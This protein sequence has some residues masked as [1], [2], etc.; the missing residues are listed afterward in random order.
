M[1]NRSQ[2]WELV[3]EKQYWQ[4]IATEIKRG[5]EAVKMNAKRLSLSIVV[6]RGRGSTTT[7]DLSEELSSVEEGFG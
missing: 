6:D 7:N 5:F 4:V 1:W 2:R 3:E